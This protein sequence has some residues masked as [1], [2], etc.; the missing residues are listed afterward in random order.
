MSEQYR[1]QH[2]CIWSG[3]AGEGQPSQRGHKFDLKKELSL[4]K[5]LKWDVQGSWGR[6]ALAY[7]IEASAV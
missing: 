2:G 3:Q 1:G 4:R 6:T 5:V 7:S